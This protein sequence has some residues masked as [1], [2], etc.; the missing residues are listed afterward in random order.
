MEKELIP[1]FIVSLIIFCTFTPVA[2]AETAELPDL[3]VDGA[4]IVLTS[5]EYFYNT[6]QVIN[7]GVISI[8]GNVI[9]HAN[10]VSIDSTSS[11][12]G[13]GV[14]NACF[15]CGENGH[16]GCS[17]A[18]GGG[19]GGGAYGGY[20][21]DGGDGGN[22]GYGGATDGGQWQ[23]GGGGG[24]SGG[25]IK[26]HYSKRA[27]FNKTTYS[28][29]DCNEL[30]K[31]ISGNV[32]LSGGAGGLRGGPRATNGEPGDNGTISCISIKTI[33]NDAWEHY[34]EYKIA[35]DGRP[36][37]D[38]DNK[39]IDGDG[40]YTENVTVSEGSSYC[41]P[42][43]VWTS[44][45]ETFD[46]V[47]N[48]TKNSLQRCNIKE[49]YY[50]NEHRWVS[51]DELGLPKDHLFAWRWFADINKTRK[52]GV[53]YYEWEPQGTQLWRDGF[54][55]ATDADED[56]A[57][58][59]IFADSLV[60]VGK[61]NETFDYA[62]EAKMILNDIWDKEVRYHAERGKYYLSAGDKYKN[63]SGSGNVGINPSYFAP[64]SYRIFD[65]FDK[66]DNHKWM[67]LVNSSYDIIEESSWAIL[68]EQEGVGL[69]PNWLMLDAEGNI[70]DIDPGW[71]ENGSDFG[72]DAFRTLWRV[73]VDYA[74]YNEQ[75]AFDYLKKNGTGSH[76]LL[77]N[78]YNKYGKIHAVH[79]HNGTPKPIS[80]ENE[81]F[82]F[83]GAYLALFHKSN[84]TRMYN[85][86][87][88]KLIE[89]Y[90]ETGYWGDNPYDYYGQNWAWFG[91]GLYDGLIKNFVKLGHDFDTER[92]ENPYPSIMGTHNG[93]IK[94]NHDV[95]ASKMYTYS[96][97]GTGGHSENVR[98]Y[99]DAWSV[100]ANWTGYQGAED[101]HYIE[102]FEPFTLEANV[103]YNYIIKT[104]S[105]PQIH[106]NTTLTVSDGEIS[107]AEFIDANG[108]IY[109]DWI[110]AIR[111]E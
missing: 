74:W 58:A 94:P 13:D 100:E 9:I 91:L 51:T 26:I 10:T 111:L 72:W 95:V 4:T 54:D 85:H 82:G 24:G 21:G 75:R 88:N 25:R 35:S 55:A 105:Y 92:P 33:L 76:S 23:G 32:D 46:K 101:Y 87:L 96:C 66:N 7:G 56:I 3:I 57:L 16:G 109:Y 8:K 22:G 15:G 1:I 11:I 34:K 68:G 110:P 39:D 47:W 79:H 20:G 48:W 64:Y 12:V 2:I 37:C 17:G 103:T 49:V 65:K 18:E 107:C 61:W 106:H 43:A 104:G 71:H 97:V 78:E 77:E 30:L 44:D 81:N 40:N 50:W 38:N 99:N 5:G 86:M 84:N 102:F 19:G 27:T 70:T 14:G 6:V 93:T 31:A 108:K 36:L 52:D 69:P 67:E 41:M 42:R 83:N 63:M 45:Q 89:D 60:K 73:V 80:C 62:N 98:F 59:L 90:D 29:L 53:I 28:P